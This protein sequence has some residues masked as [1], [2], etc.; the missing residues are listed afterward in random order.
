MSKH[1]PGPWEMRMPHEAR[2]VYRPADPHFPIYVPGDDATR[3]ADARLI[4]AAPEMLGALKTAVAQ[5]EGGSQQI[6]RYGD[7][8]R[9]I[10]AAIAKAEGVTNEE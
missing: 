3:A 9:I 5:L 10:R 1:T 4:A 6:P 2:F 8:D 7:T